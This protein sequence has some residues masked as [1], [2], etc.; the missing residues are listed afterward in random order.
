M[1]IIN[2]NKNKNKNKNFQNKFASFNKTSA[3][4]HSSLYKT[5]K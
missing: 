2:N 5:F 1:P 3:K 4:L